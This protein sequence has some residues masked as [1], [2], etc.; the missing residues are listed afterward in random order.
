MRAELLSE[1]GVKEAAG[2]LEATH[3]GGELEVH[4]D[5]G[6]PLAGGEL[7]APLRRPLTLRFLGLGRSLAGLPVR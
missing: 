5:E 3:A 2:G 6:R 1:G 4:Q 7:E